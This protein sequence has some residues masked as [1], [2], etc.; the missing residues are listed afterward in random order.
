MIAVMPPLDRLF[1]IIVVLI[2]LLK[3]IFSL[4]IPL[5]GLYIPSKSKSNSTGEDF[6]QCFLFANVNIVS[7]LLF[8]YEQARKQQ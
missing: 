2:S 4:P 1:T 7:K 8:S 5:S 6:H 3:S